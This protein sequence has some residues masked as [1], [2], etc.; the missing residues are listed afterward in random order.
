MKNVELP[1]VVLTDQ[2]S[3]NAIHNCK[4]ITHEMSWE[5]K[6]DSAVAA[7]ASL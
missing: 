5:E 3:K 1:V 7:S 2:H 6:C 4:N